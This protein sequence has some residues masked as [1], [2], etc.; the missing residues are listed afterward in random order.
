MND[1]MKAFKKNLLIRSQII[2][3]DI[4]DMLPQY[5]KVVTSEHVAFDER[6]S[7]LSTKHIQKHLVKILKIIS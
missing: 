7:T 1:E 2:Y 6:A 3:L 5:Y 4:Y